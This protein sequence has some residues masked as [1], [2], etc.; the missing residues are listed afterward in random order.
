M[1][2]PA[3][4]TDQV[5]I[6]RALEPGREPRAPRPLRPAKAVEA[7]DRASSPAGAPS[8]PS[9]STASP[10]RQIPAEHARRRKILGRRRAHAPAP[11]HTGSCDTTT[12]PRGSRR[13]RAPAP[14]AR[15][16]KAAT[17]TCCSD[18]TRLEPE[19]GVLVV[20]RMRVAPRQEGAHRQRQRRVVPPGHRQRS[21][22]S[23][24]RCGTNSSCSIRRAVGQAVGPRRPRLVGE[25]LQ[26]RT[27]LR[28]EHARPVALAGE[29]LGFG[30]VLD[31]GIQPVDQHHAAGRRRRSGEQ[32]RVV[33]PG[34]HPELV[35]EAKPPWPSAS[36]HSVPSSTA[37]GLLIARS[38]RGDPGFALP[39]AG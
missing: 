27:M 37:I 32:Q 11:P 8:A 19:A 13:W 29:E 28:R 39:R 15:R 12:A 34:A 4:A 35:P 22:T 2:L 31:P 3:A 5:G 9:S 14:S 17:P 18:V 20:Q 6:A 38:P 36:S 10:W 25:R 23:A 26:R 21:A 33:P 1:V 16:R 24:R 30:A 7:L